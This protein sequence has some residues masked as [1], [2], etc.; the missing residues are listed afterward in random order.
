MD[1]EVAEHLAGVLA[2]LM[3][4]YS[5]DR[6]GLGAAAPHVK[7]LWNR[8]GGTMFYPTADDFLQR[9]IEQEDTGLAGTPG[10]GSVPRL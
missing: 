2:G 10:G 7:W 6:A 5:I 4:P 9:I 8:Y 3:V 1:R